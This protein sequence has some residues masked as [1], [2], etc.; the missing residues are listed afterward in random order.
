MLGTGQMAKLC[1]P[2]MTPGMRP[3]LMAGGR[4]QGPLSAS[5]GARGPPI[6]HYPVFL[7]CSHC[8]PHSSGGSNPSSI[9][10]KN[11]LQNKNLNMAFLCFKP[12]SSLPLSTG[13]SPSYIFSSKLFTGVTSPSSTI[14]I[15]L[16]PLTVPPC[17]Q[18]C[19]LHT[20]F[21]LSTEYLFMAPSLLLFL[22]V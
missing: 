1:H 7:L 2:G 8:Q 15:T 16:M 17:P 3:A 20:S 9:E 6:S 19:T 4:G 13:L 5:C 10:L 18:S 14:T 21:P 11:V 22:T 12:F